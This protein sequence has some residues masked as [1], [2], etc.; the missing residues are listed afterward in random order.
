MTK[1]QLRSEMKLRRDGLSG[2]ERSTYN[3]AIR[4]LLYQSK[5]YRECNTLFSYISFGSEI[6]THPVIHQALTDGKKVYIPRVNR[7][8]MEFYQIRSMK[9]LIISKFGVPEPPVIEQNRYILEEGKEIDERYL[10]LLPGLAFDIHGNRIGY[11]GGYYDKY[12]SG[13]P[14]DYFNKVALAY[15]FQIL[16]ALT[17]DLHDVQADAIITPEGYHQ[18]ILL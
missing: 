7:T 4:Q 13:Y 8:D 3:E 15:E 9:G 12:L 6:D 5:E 1:E 18:C 17:A 14:K 16:T 11:G 2:Q 10:M